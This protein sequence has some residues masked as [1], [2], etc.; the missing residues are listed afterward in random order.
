MRRPILNKGT[1]HVL[2][3]VSQ[4]DERHNAA[5]LLK[6]CD[7]EGRAM[8]YQLQKEGRIVTRTYKILAGLDIKVFCDWVILGEKQ[9]KK[10]VRC[11]SNVTEDTQAVLT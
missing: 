6:L 8:R 2:V 5:D 7:L 4:A 10:A 1:A 9:T 11:S 3:E